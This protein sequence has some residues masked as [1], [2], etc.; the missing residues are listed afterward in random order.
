M[1][2]GALLLPKCWIIGAGHPGVD[3]SEQ[4]PLFT[5]RQQ[6]PELRAALM[7]TGAHTAQVAA[8]WSYP[9][10]DH[11]YFELG[12]MLHGEQHTRLTGRSLRQQAGDLIF[13]TPFEAHASTTPVASSFYCL[14]FDIDDLELRRLLCLIGTRVFRSGEAVLAP[15][16]PVLRRMAETDPGAAASSLAWRLEI[17]ASLFKLFAVL[18][19]SQGQHADAPALPQ[20]ALQTAERL[21]QWIEHEVEAGQETSIAAA[22]RRL[23]YTPSYGNA[24]FRQVYGVSAQHHRSMLKLRRA[25][26]LLLDAGL[27]VGHV[28]ERLGYSS[29][30]HFSRQFKRWSGVSPQGFRQQAGSGSQGVLRASS[31]KA[32]N[33]GLG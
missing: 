12:L 8:G 3:V 24:M 33:A 11:P 15:I 14:H 17:S 1:P 13:I 28:G 6:Q 5:Q 25:R 26:L 22:I 18:A 30:A 32:L 2:K 29:V 9:R 7:L 21:A 4:F 31:S 27:S 16:A 19:A 10:H 23:G 20:A